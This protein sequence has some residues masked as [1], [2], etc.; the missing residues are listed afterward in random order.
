MTEKSLV[1]ELTVIAG[2]GGSVVVV[3]F[4]LVVLELLPHAASATASDATMAIAPYR[5]L[6]NNTAFLLVR[7][8]SS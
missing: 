1:N 7:R 2:T 5:V 3:A 4:G 8:S 6:E